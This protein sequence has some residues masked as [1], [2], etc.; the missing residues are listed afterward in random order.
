MDVDKDIVTVRLTGESFEEVM[1]DLEKE[2]QLKNYRVVKIVN[3]DNIKM[4][5]NLVKDLKIGFKKYK[6]IEICNLFTCNDIISA[7]L[8][9]GV[10]MP[11]R[12]AVYERLDVEDIF[13]SYLK[14]TA[15][16][17]LFTSKQMN[18]AAERMEKDMEE[19][20]DALDY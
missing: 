16:A 6:I 2:I 4:R 8:R 18:K 10:F 11:Q 12:F 9:A 13:V 19:I 20:V 17:R 1:E 15:V 3:V 7:D 14:P 5:T